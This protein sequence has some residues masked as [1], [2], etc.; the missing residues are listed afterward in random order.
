MPKTVPYHFQAHLQGVRGVP[1]IA[2][3]PNPDGYINPVLEWDTN[4]PI[5]GIAWSA[6]NF[7]ADNNLFGAVYDILDTGP[8]SLVP[9]WP[10]VLRVEC[11]EPTGV[12]WAEFAHDVEPG[13]NAYQKE[14]G[15]PR[16]TGAAQRR[17]L[18]QRRR[19]DVHR[20]LRRGLH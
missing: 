13:P 19:H 16:R 14:R 3:N 7:G 5:N 15:E 8:E 1:L 2:A 6:S 10:A 12:K 11:L 4:N 18:Q 17:S 9:T 20:R